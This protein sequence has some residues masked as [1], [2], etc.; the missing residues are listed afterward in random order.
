MP[1][2][3]RAHG[4]RELPKPSGRKPDNTGATGL[5]DQSGA[6]APYQHTPGSDRQRPFT[7]LAQKDL[8][9]QRRQLPP[10]PPPLRRRLPHHL[11]VPP[12]PQCKNEPKR[13]RQMGRLRQTDMGRGERRRQLER[14][15]GIFQLS[16]QS[17]NCTSTL[18]L[19]LLHLLFFGGGFFFAFLSPYLT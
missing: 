13:H 18:R 9:N 4:V 17:V 7:G 10:L 15:G 19:Q 11:P 2:C 6:V 14:S 3:S 5:G 8:Q 1:Q 12:P 16:T